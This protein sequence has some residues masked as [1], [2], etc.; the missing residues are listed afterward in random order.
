MREQFQHPLREAI[1]WNEKYAVKDAG[2]TGLT[3]HPEV[4]GQVFHV[5]PKH[6]RM[7]P[8][9]APKISASDYWLVCSR[10]S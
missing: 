2:K 8:H 6:V 5:V 1:F 9:A 4:C 10:R 7:L 3:V